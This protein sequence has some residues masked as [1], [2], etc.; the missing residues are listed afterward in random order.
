MKTTTKVLTE[1][2]KLK[3]REYHR[4][5]EASHKE[6]VKAWHKAYNDR[7]REAI[8][9]AKES[10]QWVEERINRGKETAEVKQS[11]SEKQ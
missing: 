3:R 5:Y 2:Q 6:Q 7:K 4:K 8:R 9:K 1:E 10:A 11:K